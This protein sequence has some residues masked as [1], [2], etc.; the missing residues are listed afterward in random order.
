[1]G[2]KIT[3]ICSALAGDRYDNVRT[4]SKACKGRF[5][6]HSDGFGARAVLSVGNGVVAG[7]VTFSTLAVM[8]GKARQMLGRELR[9]PL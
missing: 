7:V 3:N 2:L 5:G 8:R 4:L 1:M 9:G 6:F